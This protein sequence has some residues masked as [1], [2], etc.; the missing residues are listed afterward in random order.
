[1]TIS[2]LC[3]KKAKVFISVLS[4]K[5]EVP[6][7]CSKAKGTLKAILSEN[8]DKLKFELDTCGLKNITGAHFHLGGKGFNG[9]IVKHIKID[10][11]TGK[12]KG[13]WSKDDCKEPLTSCL[14]KKLLSGC[15]YVNVH[16]CKYPDGEIRDQVDILH[17]H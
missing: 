14:V 7:N 6:P 13:V 8:K 1:M 3:C 4:G 10:K 11:C 9:P 16:T 12:A 5:N 15:I 2:S 17:K